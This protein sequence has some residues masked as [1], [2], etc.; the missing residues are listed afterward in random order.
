MMKKT[1]ILTFLL[2]IVLLLPVFGKTA[3]AS[4]LTE[5]KTPSGIPYSQLKQ[6]VEDYLKENEKTTASVALE[7]FDGQQTLYRTIAGYTN[8]EDKIRATEDTVYEWGSCSKLLVWVSVMQLW[9]QGRLDLEQDVKTYLP[10]DFFAKL[11]YDTP[12]TMMN[13]MN[14]TPGWQ[15]TTYEIAT[16]DLSRVVDLEQALR[17][18][19]P[20]QVYEP[21]TVCAYSNWG[22]ALAGYIVERITGQPFYAYVH[23]NIFQPLGM[24]STA[25]AAGLSDNPWVHSQRQQ[26]KCYYITEDIH[27]NLDECLNY[28][29][30]YPAGMATGTLED[31]T[32]FAKAFVPEE[33]EP[34]P[35]FRKSDTLDIMLSPTLLYGNTDL[36]RVCHGLWV[37]DFGVRTLGHGGNTNGGS[38][39]F[40]FDPQ[41]KLGVTVMT[42]QFSET[43]YNYGIPALVFGEYGENGSGEASEAVDL[44]GI[45]TCSRTFKKGFTS[46]YDM[47]SILI[48][49]KS[50]EV[51]NRYDI[52]FDEGS[53]TP[54]MGNHLVADFNGSK[55]YIY[56]HTSED[57]KVSLQTM[58]MDYIKQS[59]PVF[60][61][62]TLLILS[63]IVGIIYC[64][65]SL[66]VELILLVVRKIRK[67]KLTPHPIRKYRIITQ[68]SFVAFTAILFSVLS[69]SGLTV[70]NMW[71]RCVL[72]AIL[73]LVPVIYT[74]ILLLNRGLLKSGKRMAFAN[75]LTAVLGLIMTVN[76]VF[77]QMYN[78][79]S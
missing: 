22:T 40:L 36:S 30:L 47:L 15:E 39:Y 55:L 5:P 75:Y 28:I 64:T 41:S 38:S 25:L 2:V 67:R 69:S 62:K 52:M 66:L 32:T 19:E 42:N 46:F 49:K 73:A 6:R 78:F 48:L 77:W 50:N 63:L 53:V 20:S 17:R 1:R 54:V 44:G 18:T 45:Y 24:K 76:I 34:C 11:N 65:I 68:F 23:E 13:L 58:S 70:G 29:L 60:L 71:W 51:A 27:K 79:W 56:K 12:I 10:E 3:V 57:E 74:L 72:N 33:G 31:F 21:G 59:T 14:H 16:S 43:V 35:L 37:L 61:F 8:L 7:I 26:Q 9:E 4:E